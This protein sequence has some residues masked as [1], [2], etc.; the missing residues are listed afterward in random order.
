MSDVLIDLIKEF[1]GNIDS[2]ESTEMF[3]CINK[4]CNMRDDI[5]LELTNVISLDKVR[6]LKKNHDADIKQE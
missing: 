1:A 2:L 5:A 3:R 4:T 6:L